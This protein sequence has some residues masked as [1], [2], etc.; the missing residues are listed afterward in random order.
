MT[1]EQT[2][3]LIAALERIALRLEERASQAQPIGPHPGY[4]PA[5]PV[6]AWQTGDDLTI[7][8]TWGPVVP[9]SAAP[10]IGCGPFGPTN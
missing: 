8:N 1:K 7:R 2:E 6:F 5:Y 10:A 3:R 9:T 4:G